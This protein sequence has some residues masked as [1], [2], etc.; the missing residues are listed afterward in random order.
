MLVSRLLTKDKIHQLCQDSYETHR[1]VVRTLSP[2]RVSKK[3]LC[4]LDLR[5][6]LAP[7]RKALPAD[8]PLWLAAKLSVCQQLPQAV[9]QAHQ[10]HPIF[11]GMR[12]TAQLRALQQRCEVSL[13]RN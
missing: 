10:C 9:Y 1:G 5:V 2:V 13:F 8:C 7:Q 11:F 4:P 12:Q 6:N 3:K